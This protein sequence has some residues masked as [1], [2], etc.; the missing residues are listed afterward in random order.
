MVDE[1]MVDDRLRILDSSSIDHRLIDHAVANR[2]P[3]PSAGQRRARAN[4][5]RRAFRKREDLDLAFRTIAID[6]P[7]SIRSL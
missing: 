1:T 2:R 4:S 5:S 3:K 7:A 6:A